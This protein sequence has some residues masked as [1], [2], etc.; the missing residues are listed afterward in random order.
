MDGIAAQ[1]QSFRSSFADK[2]RREHFVASLWTVVSSSL[3]GSF[4]KGREQSRISIR[5][6]EGGAQR[7][8]SARR[9]KT[10]SEDE[11][12]E[13]LGAAIDCLEMDRAGRGNGAVIIAQP[14]P[15]IHLGTG[16]FRPPLTAYLP[17][18]GWLLGGRRDSR[19][20]RQRRASPARKTFKDARHS[21][22]PSRRAE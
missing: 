21:Y 12:L 5:H 2:H 22:I 6:K 3:G 16:I 7:A 9:K 17:P 1:I 10:S 8:R 15:Y 4:R 18:R 20:S 14:Y 13:R 19:V 11:V